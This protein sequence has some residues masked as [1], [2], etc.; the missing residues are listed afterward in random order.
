MLAERTHVILCWSALQTNDAVGS[1]P[2][3]RCLYLL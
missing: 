1:E 2:S 3:E